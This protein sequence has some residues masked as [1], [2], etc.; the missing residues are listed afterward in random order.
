MISRRKFQR[1]PASVSQ[2]VVVKR[3]THCYWRYDGDQCTIYAL[4]ALH[5]SLSFLISWGIICT[6]LKWDFTLVNGSTIT[7]C[8]VVQHCTSVCTYYL[9]LPN[10]TRLGSYYTYTESYLYYSYIPL[11]LWFT[12]WIWRNV[13]TNN[14]CRNHLYFKTRI[15]IS[16]YTGITVPKI[17]PKFE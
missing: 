7:T 4:N 6:I 1:G 16:V 5:C 2:L 3:H 11:R 10:D 12:G 9:H 15:H 13:F 14:P 8:A 17:G